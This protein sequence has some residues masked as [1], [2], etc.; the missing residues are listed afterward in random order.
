MSKRPKSPEE[1]A[2]PCCKSPL[3]VSF[4]SMFPEIGWA[5]LCP[6]HEVE[7]AVRILRMES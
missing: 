3:Q 5:N 1:K 4:M 7:L 2:C 6:A